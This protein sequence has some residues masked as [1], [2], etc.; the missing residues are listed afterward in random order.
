MI[1]I[2]LRLPDDMCARLD[3]EQKRR[4]NSGEPA[5]SWTEILYELSQHHLPLPRPPRPKPP[6]KIVS[7]NEVSKRQRG[8]GKKRWVK[9]PQEE[10]SKEMRQLAAR[11]W[12]RFT[13]EERRAEIARRQAMNPRPPRPPKPARVK[14]HGKRKHLCKAHT[15][16]YSQGRGLFGKHHGV[17]EQS[18]HLRGHS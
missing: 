15:R 18:E 10:R 9:V 7:T 5:A 11:Y 1:D 8:N 17:F 3:A 16:D 12:Q 13:P 2:K 4:V 6:R 14:C